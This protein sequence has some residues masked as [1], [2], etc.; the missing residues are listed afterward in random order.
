MFVYITAS[1]LVL[2]VPVAFLFSGNII[3]NLYAEI[4]GSI[5]GFLLY[6]V[7][8]IG[9]SMQE[10]EAGMDIK[11][12]KEIN[13]GDEEIMGGFGGEIMSLIPRK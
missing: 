11:N 2:G 3:V 5:A 8:S 12:G 10:K 6:S 7:G 4:A 9:P 1:T 13:D